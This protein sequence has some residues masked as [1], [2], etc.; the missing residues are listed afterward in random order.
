M[1][2]LQDNGDRL[3][4][5]V[6][7]VGEIGVSALDS[8]EDFSVST[9]DKQAFNDTLSQILTDYDEFMSTNREKIERL[10]RGK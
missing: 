6:G 10:A 1:A 7:W 8:N 3:R 4:N 5:I 2:S 9:A